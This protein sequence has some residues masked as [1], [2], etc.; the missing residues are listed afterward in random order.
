M[1]EA[2]LEANQYLAG[3]PG[4]SECH[5]IDLMPFQRDNDRQ[6]RLAKEAAAEERE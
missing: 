1:D 2:R 4:F 3:D 6:R 5:R